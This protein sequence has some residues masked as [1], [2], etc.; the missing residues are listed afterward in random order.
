MNQLKAKEN[1]HVVFWL[2][3]D[4]AWL[5]HFRL[6][7]MTMV[8]PTILLGFWIT[9]RTYRLAVLASEE[10]AK[11]D[12]FVGLA[13]SESGINGKSSIRE[14]WSDFYHNLAI[15]CWILGNGVWMT[16]EFFFDD[17]IRPL[18]MPFFF[19]GL[20]VVSFYYVFVGKRTVKETK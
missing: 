7:G 14:I 9:L 17:S 2:L 6:L 16:G 8:L 5:M 15:S 12:E 4:F 1:L 18:A 10:F 11:R 13:D 19:L 20:L 3:K